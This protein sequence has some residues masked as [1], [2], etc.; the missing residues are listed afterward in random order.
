MYDSS[1]LKPRWS[2]PARTETTKTCHKGLSSELVRRADQV[3]RIQFRQM[4]GQ[5]MIRG[6]NPELRPIV[7]MIQF[8]LTATRKAIG[9]SRFFPILSG[10]V[11]IHAPAL[12]AAHG[13]PEWHHP[14][15]RF[16]RA[17]AKPSR[18]VRPCRRAQN[19]SSQRQKAAI[20]AGK[21]TPYGLERM[22]K[23]NIVVP[24]A[25]APIRLEALEG[26]IDLLLCVLLVKDHAKCLA[27][28][29]STR[30]GRPRQDSPAVLYSARFEMRRTVAIRKGSCHYWP[31]EV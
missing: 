15:V 24:S 1:P 28:Q 27:V 10:F 26:Y 12:R 5:S 11:T 20:R 17:R 7:S 14:F 16:A 31:F 4:S 13:Y 19:Q 8:N 22:R 9:Y 23:T 25:I 30:K 3:G 2:L 6:L 29:R 21:H 18:R